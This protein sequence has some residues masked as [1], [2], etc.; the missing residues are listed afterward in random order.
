MLLM[1]TFNNDKPFPYLSTERI[2]DIYHYT[3]SIALQL[4]Q[5]LPY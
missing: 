5:G 2:R 3:R 4:P 1:N